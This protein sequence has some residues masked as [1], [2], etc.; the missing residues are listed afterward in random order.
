M[1]PVPHRDTDIH[2]K[3]SQV[4]EP[5]SNADVKLS[6]G[7]DDVFQK[8][9]HRQNVFFTG[10]AG[11]GK[12]LLLRCIID[13]C[14][15]RGLK[16][17]ELAI[18]AS[19]GMASMNIGG[20]TIHAWAG[21]GL[22]AESTDIL[23]I[24]ILGKALYCDYGGIVPPAMENLNEDD[25]PMRRTT[26]DRWKSCKVLIIDESRRISFPLG[27]FSSNSLYLASIHDR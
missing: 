1:G 5:P 24:T 26:V 21:I 8:V 6:P 18:T 22:G 25:L 10:S 7:Q 3:S 19:T 23:L 16:D 27:L 17:T 12:S 2:A 15:E 20:C 14:R 4:D 9:K 13:W 11:T